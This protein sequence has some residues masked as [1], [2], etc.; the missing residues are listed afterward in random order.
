MAQAIT[1]REIPVAVQ[2]TELVAKLISAGSAACIAEAITLPMDCAKIKLQVSKDIPV[3]LCS[4][5]L[6]YR[7]M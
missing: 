7:T 2:G 1:K 5:S 3:C 6:Y 4:L